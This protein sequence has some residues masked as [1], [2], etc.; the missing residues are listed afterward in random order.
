VELIWSVR[1]RAE[2]AYLEE[3]E[4]G[5]AAGKV[6]FTL[7]ESTTIGHLDLAAAGLERA[8][9]LSVLLCGPVPMRK[10]LIGQL[11]GLGVARDRI[12]YEEFT[13]R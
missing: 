1:S 6:R 12:Y 7:H 11:L 4:A 9:E 3:V 2:A 5:V 8:A 10:A 13:L